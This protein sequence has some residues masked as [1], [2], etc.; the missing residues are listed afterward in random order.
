MSTFKCT[1]A[2]D[3][4]VFKR[5]PGEYD[6]FCELKEFLAKGDFRFFNLETTVHDY[7]TAGAA[8]S[9]GS[10]FCTEPAVLSDMHNFGFNV[11]TPANNHTLDYGPD[12]CLKTLEYVKK[13]NF[14]T[15]GTG[16]HL[17]EASAP[18]Y[19][20][21][22]SGRYAVI[23]CCSSFSPDCM[24]GE[25]TRTMA[26]RPG[27]N[28]INVETKYF[29][30]PEDIEILRRIAEETKI[31]GAADLSRKNGY[32]P[33]L[34]EGVAEFGPLK[35]SAGEKPC[36]KTKVKDADLNRVKEAIREARF[37]AD[38]VVVS[39]HSHQV[40]G[41]NREE[42]AEFLVKF[43]HDC[44]D[45]GAD[46]IVGTGPHVMRPIE[47]YNGKPIFYC[48][49][50]F[51]TQNETMKFVPDGMFA[52]QSISGNG[53]MV[54]MYET[55]SGGGKRGIFYTQSMFEAFVPYWSATDG[56]LTEV[57]LMPVEMGFGQSRG[58]GGWPRPCYD[59]GIMERLV[60]MSKAYGTQIEIDENGIGHVKL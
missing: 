17:G 25:Q 22:L 7:E 33:P 35:F 8:L 20:D 15:S 12:G 4:M 14:V 57:S 29:V 3:S 19:L 36:I 40:Q 49:G 53:N 55:R 43:S 21:T 52:K 24:A 38:Y 28:G 44:I 48:L 6:G 45:A 39:V 26:G 50:D 13:E 42:P 34:P 18:G 47:I 16:K 2:G 10:W 11:L 23:S 54:D 56:K 30:K 60:E 31:N 1:A 9:G 37:F 32:T 5:F 58:M 46:A 59:K 51:I 41:D 27:L